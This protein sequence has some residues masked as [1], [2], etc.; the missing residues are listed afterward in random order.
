MSIYWVHTRKG[1]E[2][3]LSEC[4]GF[5]WDDW[6]IAKNW[7]SH[8][9]TPTECEEVFFNQPLTV[10]ADQP[11]STDEERYYALGRTNTDRGLFVALTIRG[12][13]IRVISAR[14]QTSREKRI[15]TRLWQRL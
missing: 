12:T 10:Q 13:L 9:V 2:I 8:Q 11:H 7:E 15:Y 1:P 5:Q 6:N 14:D 4:T 3:L